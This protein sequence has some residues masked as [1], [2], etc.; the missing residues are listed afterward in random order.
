MSILDTLAAAE[1][2]AE[3]NC[4]YGLKLFRLQKLKM[5]PRPFRLRIPRRTA[6]RIKIPDSIFFGLLKYDLDKEGVTQEKADNH[7]LLEDMRIST[8]MDE[9]VDKVFA[10]YEKNKTKAV[11]FWQTTYQRTGGI[12]E[13]QSHAGSNSGHG[14]GKR[15]S[16]AFTS[17]GGIQAADKEQSGSHTGEISRGRRKSFRKDVSFCRTDRQERTNPSSI[18]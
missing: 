2:T 4:R 7:S 15:H 17:E 3:R 9:A 10:F 18:T 1:K 5:Q 14:T 13:K 8:A 12:P 11:R 6:G 16:I